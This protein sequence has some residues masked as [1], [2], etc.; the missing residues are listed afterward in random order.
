MAENQE[1]LPEEFDEE[2]EE[3]TDEQGTDH[4]IKVSG[5]Y[6]EWFLDYASY[7][8]LERAVPHINDGLKPV[9]RRILHSLHEL[10]DGRFHKVANVI[11]NTM[12]YHPHGDAS[13]G[14][15]ITQIGQKD[16]MFDCQ[17]NW[18]NI[19]T[20][21][22]A[23]APRYI[24][25]RLSKFALAVAFNHKTT[26]WLASYDGR[27]KE[28]V[29]L[30]MKFPL[31]LAQ[32]V[33]GIAVGL[34][35]KILPHNFVELIEQSIAHLK[36]KR[37]KIFPDFPTGGMV[38]VSNYNDGLRGGKLRVRAKISVEDKKTLK[39]SDIPFSTT[40]TSLIDS[41]LKANDK[42][43]IKIRKIEDNTSEFVEILVHLKDV[44]PDKTIDALYAFTDCEVSISPNS[45]VIEND[46]PQFFGVTEILKIN[47]EQTVHL[48]TREL[49]IKKGELEEQLHF[50]SL[51]KI[52]IENKIY[53]EF[54][55]KTYE[56][57][58]ELT[59][60]RLEPFVKNFVRE[61]T[62]DDIVRLLEIRMRRITKHD[63]DKADEKIAN[64]ND[65]IKQVEY[66]LEHIIDYTITYYQDLK[67][68]FGEGRE[69]KTEI[70]SF[71]SI[72]K[73]KVAVAN[74]KLYANFKEGF[75]GT[76]LKRGEG[77][78]IQDCSDIDDVI[79]IRNDG[80]LQVSKVSEKAFF[81][82]DI[83]HVGIWKKGDKRTIYNMVY[84]DGPR[85]NTYV[86]RFAVNSITRDRE[87]DLTAGTKGSKVL[88]LTVNPNGE[89]E[90]VKI[91]LRQK[92]HIKRLKFDFDFADQDIKGRS[93]KGNILTKHAVLKIELKEEGV[94]TLGA[95]KIW[96]DDT[97]Q[98]LN[99]EGRGNL[100]GEYSGDDKILT[101]MQSGHYKLSPY[102]LSTKFDEDFIIMEKF[103]PE[104]VYSM[105]YFDGEKQQYNVKRFNLETTPNKTLLITE[106]L[107]SF[108]EIVTGHP[109]PEV[110]ISYDKRKSK[111]EDE[112]IKLS[113][114]I[115]VKG[116]KA[117]GN[118]LTT[119]VIKSIELI[120]PELPQDEKEEN[121]T[122]NE[123]NNNEETS[124]AVTSEVKVEEKEVEKETIKK[125]ETPEKPKKPAESNKEEEPATSKQEERPKKEEIAATP[126]VEQ[127]SKPSAEEKPVEIELEIEAPNSE[128]ENK[129]KEEDKPK[130]E[131]IP[132][133]PKKKDPNK[134]KEPPSN[135]ITLEL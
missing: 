82:K 35:C 39:I 16:I 50:A 46:K 135:Q 120:E 26:E 15:A 92:P 31:L 25:V 116:F 100:I 89:A 111:K 52:F 65:E 29:T 11:G 55:G 129:P 70:K 64:L 32:G 47:T 128:K 110:I 74:E 73:S 7:V 95:R 10:D 83:L 76:K 38:D 61:V 62:H 48:L 69:R 37:I 103:D 99:S 124:Q 105:I 53:I 126:K 42:G 133:K 58:I 59:F 90:V 87:Y 3:A 121:E 125:V 44:S 112:R 93:A 130:G 85:G 80:V 131:S 98:R 104:K 108:L 84:Q 68:R 122:E 2:F 81:G 40:T 109:E 5:M 20:G 113:E 72:E 28:P 107:D 101:I 79:V 91:V 132:V 75:V 21:D 106:H 77:D 34:A 18:G 8:I 60:K 88:Y 102:A 119:D 36:G 49:E 45:V 14:E 51:E 30:P 33:E 13:I 23:A 114:F 41:I 86:K 57:A 127:K 78:F 9:Q 12:K 22:R 115:S 117:Q 66:D 97:V 134:G 118:K 1:E 43:K 24:E 6:Q 94:S 71:E 96:F 54:D 67:K 19:F 63:A 56:E 4:V 17:G 123:E 27:G